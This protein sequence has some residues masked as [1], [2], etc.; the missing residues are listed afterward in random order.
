MCYVLCARKAGNDE[1]DQ[2]VRGEDNSQADC[3]PNH[4]A[5]TLGHFFRAAGAGHPGKTAVDEHQERKRTDD[6][7]CRADDFADEGLGASNAGVGE[8]IL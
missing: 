1:F 8:G 3:R 7:E 4:N 5:F 2:G 6:S